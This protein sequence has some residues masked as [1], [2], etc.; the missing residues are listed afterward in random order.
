MEVF[1][2]RL[3]VATSKGGIYRLDDTSRQWQDVSD[4]ARGRDVL[5][6]HS[7]GF[8][9]YAGYNSYGTQQSGLAVFSGDKWIDIGLTNWLVRAMANTGSRLHVGTYGGYFTGINP[10]TVGG[11]HPVVAGLPPNPA[12]NALE[13]VGD[14]VFAGLGPSQSEQRATLFVLNSE[15]TQWLNV[16][17]VVDEDIHCI[18]ASGDYLFLG[19][20]TGVGRLN[21]KD[22]R[23]AVTSNGLPGNYTVEALAAN[24]D[25]IFAGLD[26]GGVWVSTDAGNNWLNLN[27]FELRNERVS[28]LKVRNGS[29]LFVGTGSGKVFVLTI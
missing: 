17:E 25:R 24:G 29:E 28:S 27:T 23:F 16:P 22:L 21:T 2:G 18:A 9:L 6:L 13:T 11:L 26:G 1:E 12:I 19:T 8:S 14:S 7:V 10:A 3:F 20:T 15:G 5:A 4:T